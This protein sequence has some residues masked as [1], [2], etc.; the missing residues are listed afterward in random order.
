MH[1]SE[2]RGA[3]I[4]TKLSGRFENELRAHEHAAYLRYSRLAGEHAPPKRSFKPGLPTSLP[5]ELS[6][7][8]TQRS[9]GSNGAKSHASIAPW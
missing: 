5:V 1:A 9:W 6:S 3:E 2:T 8:N 4:A 7:R